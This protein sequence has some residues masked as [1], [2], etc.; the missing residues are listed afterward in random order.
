[1][2]NGTLLRMAEAEE[3]EVVITCDKNMFKEQMVE[4]RNLAVVELPTTKFALLLP[5]FAV[6]RDAVNSAKPGKY[7]RINQQA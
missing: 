7:Y 4:G 3:F 2:R 6:V 5:I 1:M